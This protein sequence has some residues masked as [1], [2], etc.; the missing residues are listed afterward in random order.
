[1][2]KPNRDKKLIRFE[3]SIF[4]G[5]G[6]VVKI[7]KFLK[8]V[9][10]IGSRDKASPITECYIFQITRTEQNLKHFWWQIKLFKYDLINF[11]LTLYGSQK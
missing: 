2:T 10:T 9:F 3:R 8:L 5:F 6:G 1:M 11:S 7:D 4:G